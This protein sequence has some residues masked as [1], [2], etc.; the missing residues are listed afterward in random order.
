MC[1]YS[2]DQYGLRPSDIDTTLCTHLVL[3]FLEVEDSLLSKG[4]TEGEAS[5]E[6]V[7]SLKNNNPS[8][9]VMASVGGGAN[10]HGFH[11]MVSD[12]SKTDRYAASVVETLRK[13][14]LDGLD[15][16]WEFPN[17]IRNGKLYF[18]RLL[19]RL[20]AAFEE[21]ARIS[22]KERLILSAAVA[23]QSLLMNGS[24]DIP[25]IAK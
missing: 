19:Q 17:A 8:L 25:E 15:I 16:D 22:G 7:A 12:A 13:H 18:T 20:C 4:S 1:Y 2:W 11:S 6:A 14:N 24:Y 21:E 5:Y 23:P 9:K 3:G 10:S